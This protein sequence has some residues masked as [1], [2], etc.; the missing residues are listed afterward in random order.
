MMLEPHAITT[1]QVRDEIH[2]AIERFGELG[3]DDG[4]AIAWLSLG[5]TE[6]MPCRYDLAREEFERAIGHARRA[7]NR[8][9]LDEAYA[10]SLATDCFGSTRPE[11]AM[12]RLDRAV[13]ELGTEGF[14]GGHLAIVHRGVFLAMLGSLEEARQLLE[15]AVSKARGLGAR[16]WLGASLQWRVFVEE[17]GGDPEA[18]EQAAR[19]AYTIQVLGG[20]E[21]HASTD[22]GNLA[23]VLCRLGRFDEAVDL[24]REAMDAPADDLASQSIGRSAM[25][26]IRS[27]A[28]RHEDAFA[29]GWAAVEMLSGAQTPDFQGTAWLDL[30]KVLRAA[31]REDEAVAAA[32]ESLALHERK[33]NLPAVAAVE[34][35]LSRSAG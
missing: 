20:D 31:G 19:E 34:G 2:R 5:S 9:V 3:D 25:A 15:I 28:G 33:G 13:A 27:A 22:A 7:G 14:L 26:L 8:R 30:A 11:P 29:L 4:L 17:F 21:G 23:R 12:A 18:A 24:A 16:L 1:A 10:M 6:W 35:F 32:R